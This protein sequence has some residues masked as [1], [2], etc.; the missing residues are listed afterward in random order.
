MG[1]RPLPPDANVESTL[2]WYKGEKEYKPWV[3]ALEDFLKGEYH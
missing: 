3:E 2:I 1:F